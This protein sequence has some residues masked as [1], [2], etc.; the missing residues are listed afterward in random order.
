VIRDSII[1]DSTEES[2][3]AI[4]SSLI[5]SVRELRV[6]QMA[7]ALSLDV[8]KSSLTFPKIEQYALADQMRRAS[9]SIC[10]NLAEGFAKQSY[11]VPEFNRFVM[12]AIGSANEMIVWN[13]YALA[14]EY[15]PQD[16]YTK[17][18]D[19]FDHIAKMLHKLKK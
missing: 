9:K 13:D 14:L 5:S 7:F 12:M 15:I 8:H 18:V 10:A 4:K 2:V 16:Q 19:G 11:S 1:R 3:V 17:W 6:Y